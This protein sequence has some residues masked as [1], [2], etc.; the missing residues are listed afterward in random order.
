MAREQLQAEL[1]R[2]EV[3]ANADLAAL[4]CRELRECAERY[5]QEK[6]KAGALDFL[7]LLLKAR[8]L[9]EGG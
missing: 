9:V 4:L 5:E 2:F 8:N 7:D 6:A 1:T 3:D